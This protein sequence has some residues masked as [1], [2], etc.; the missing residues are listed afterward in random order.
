MTPK[1]PFSGNF[2]LANGAGN[3]V[4]L[5]IVG[6]LEQSYLD[7]FRYFAAFQDD[8]STYRYFWMMQT[9]GEIGDLFVRFANCFANLTP[10]SSRALTISTKHSDLIL[11][12]YLSDYCTYTM[13]MNMLV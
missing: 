1:F 2:G 7:H 3:I 9:G 13:Q 10:C 4:H 12:K 8:H 5:D 11:F 6:A